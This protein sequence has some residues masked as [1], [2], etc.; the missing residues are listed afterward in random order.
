MKPRICICCGESM[1]GEANPLSRNPNVCASCSSMVDG[2]EESGV[3]GLAESATARPQ[4][5]CA[6]A[7][8]KMPDLAEAGVAGAHRF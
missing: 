6:A 2:M 4:S 5:A 7:E 1:L 8:E 3:A